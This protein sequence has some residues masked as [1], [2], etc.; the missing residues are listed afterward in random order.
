MVKNIQDSI[1]NGQEQFRTLM[2]SQDD[3][4]IVDNNC[5]YYRNYNIVVLVSK[6]DDQANMWRPNS[7]SFFVLV[8]VIIAVWL[9]W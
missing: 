8:H 2:Y 4:L 7:T 5:Y 3:S 6:N 9:Q 1:K